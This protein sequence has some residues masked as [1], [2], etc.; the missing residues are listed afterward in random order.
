MSRGGRLACA[1]L[2]HYGE[3]GL[4]LLEVGACHLDAYGV[5]ELVAVVPAAAYEAV[6]ALVE[7]VVVVVGGA[8]G[9]R[10]LAGVVV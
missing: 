9:R 5:A 1:S 10:A 8:H 4:S 2:A 7:V 6:V 3:V